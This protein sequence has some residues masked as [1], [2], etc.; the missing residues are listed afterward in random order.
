MD[1]GAQSVML[2]GM[3]EMLG[4]SADNW[5]IMDVSGI[6]YKVMDYFIFFSVYSS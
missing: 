4:L 2:T 5:A 1:S 3:R 6:W